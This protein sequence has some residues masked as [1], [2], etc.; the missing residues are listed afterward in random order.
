MVWVD[1]L[2]TNR[3]ESHYRRLSRFFLP[4]AALSLGVL[5]ASGVYTGIYSAPVKA[6]GVFDFDVMWRIPFGAAYLATIGYKA[7]ALG[8]C[9][10]LAVTMARALRAASYPIVAGGDSTLAMG[11]IGGREAT[12]TEAVARDTTL[13]RMAAANGVIG[14]SLAA[15]IAVAVYLHYIS[16]LAVFLPE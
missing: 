3:E 4:A 2:T 16:H 9:G 5:A 11:L 1:R 7:L 12:K 13:Y 6:P 10:V 14:L 15:A 8:A